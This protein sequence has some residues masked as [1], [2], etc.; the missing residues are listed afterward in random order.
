MVEQVWSLPIEI[1]G[2]FE[3]MVTEY[4]LG[5]VRDLPLIVQLAMARMTVL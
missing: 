2:D 3:R 5:L 1:L 4:G